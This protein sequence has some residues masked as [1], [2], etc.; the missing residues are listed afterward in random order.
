MKIQAKLCI[1]LVFMCFACQ[2]NPKLITPARL[3]PVDSLTQMVAEM[4]MI[5]GLIF[6]LEGKEDMEALTYEQYS[7]LFQRYS[8]TPEQLSANIEFYFLQ[9]SIREYIIREVNG[10]VELYTQ[11]I[12]N[13]IPQE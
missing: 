4:Y 7:P 9:D 12:L 6:A 3:L 11:Q 8:M 13:E 2:R 5:D 1:L 10:K